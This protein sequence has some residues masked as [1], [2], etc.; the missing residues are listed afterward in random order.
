M[1]EHL[2]YVGDLLLQLKPIGEL[3][4]R[5][6]IAL[7]LP[8][9]GADF[10]LS[11]LTVWYNRNVVEYGANVVWRDPTVIVEVVPRIALEIKV[12]VHIECERQ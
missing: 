8:E 4:S 3:R 5:D 11:V 12:A 7:I 10:L 2:V 6:V 9:G 1:K